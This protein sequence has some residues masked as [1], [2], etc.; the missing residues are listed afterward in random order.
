MLSGGGFGDSIRRLRLAPPPARPGW[1][2]CSWCREQ[3]ASLEVDGHAYCVTCIGDLVAK[4]EN[5]P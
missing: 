5:T 2:D 3:R 1:P 4:G